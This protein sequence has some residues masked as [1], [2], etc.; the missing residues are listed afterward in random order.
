M[1]QNEK[2]TS[3]GANMQKI[4]KEKSLELLNGVCATVTYVDG[5]K[6]VTVSFSYD[7]D[8]V[9]IS[10]T[11]EQYKNEVDPINLSISRTELQE[12][13]VKIYGEK[14]KSIVLLKVYTLDELK[15]LKAI[16]KMQDLSELFLN[17]WKTMLNASKNNQHEMIVNISKQVENYKK[18]PNIW[19]LKAN[20]INWNKTVPKDEETKLEETA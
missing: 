1:P 6:D 19:V 4:L 3:L 2:I 9:Y 12:F 11:F 8:T 16:K 10:K 13:A 7:N 17:E 14:A 5:K 15:K 18:D 20:K